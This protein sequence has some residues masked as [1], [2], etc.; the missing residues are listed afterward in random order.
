MGRLK[1]QLCGRGLVPRGD[2]AAD[3]HT[4]AAASS[5]CVLPGCSCKR[6]VF[7][8]LLE[9]SHCRVSRDRR[10]TWARVDK[11]KAVPWIFPFRRHHHPSHRDRPASLPAC[12]DRRRIGTRW[13]RLRVLSLNCS[14]CRTTSSIPRTMTS[15]CTTHMRRS[16]DTLSESLYRGGIIL[17]RRTF[18]P[19]ATFWRLVGVRSW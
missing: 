13:A 7:D 3:G 12:P 15:I 11:G 2:A 16:W 18:R 6:R 19:S 10:S 9:Y 5:V 17:I 8:V 4:Q 14:P 1:R